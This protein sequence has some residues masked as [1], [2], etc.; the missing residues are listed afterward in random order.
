MVESLVDEISLFYINSGFLDFDIVNRSLTNGGGYCV[1][2]VFFVS[3][4]LSCGY[5]R[6]CSCVSSNFW[7][8]SWSINMILFSKRCSK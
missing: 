4:F 1:I 2:S 8:N 7:V 3:A 5:C 6:K